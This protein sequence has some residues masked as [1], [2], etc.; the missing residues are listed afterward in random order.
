MP[1]PRSKEAPHDAP[2]HLERPAFWTETSDPE[3][4]FRALDVLA[5]AAKPGRADGYAAH[6]RRTLPRRRYR[7]ARSSRA[8]RNLRT[9]RRGSIAGVVAACPRCRGP[10]GLT[11]EAQV[12]L[13][14]WKEAPARGL[15]QLAAYL[16]RESPWLRLLLLRLQHR[17]WELVGLVRGAQRARR[18]QG[19][20][21]A[22]VAQARRTR[23]TGSRGS[24]SRQA[25]RW[26]A[27]AHCD[28]LAYAP[29]VLLRKPSKDNLSLTPLTAPLLLLESVG[30]FSR[31]G[32][33]TLPSRATGGPDRH[34]H[35]NSGAHRHHQRPCRCPRLRRRRTGAAGAARHLRREPER[36]RIRALDGRA[37]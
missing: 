23:G 37:D 8:V 36:R 15:E 27:R 28:V 1:A 31:T 9:C 18:A 19:G 3:S 5:T 10:L 32:A 12:L 21:F 24:N 16:V 17:D 26:L 29:G 25:A 35:T 2:L 6:R 14:H 11:D 33:L 4:W 7:M 13:R 22:V 20:R 34:R 30:W